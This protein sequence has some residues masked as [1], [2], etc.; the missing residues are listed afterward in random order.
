MSQL[1][2]ETGTTSFSVM[3]S[4]TSRTF[5]PIMVYSSSKQGQQQWQNRQQHADCQQFASL[6]PQLLP[7]NCYS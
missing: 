1:I 4:Y 6:Y 5:R 2:Y 7:Y 3:R